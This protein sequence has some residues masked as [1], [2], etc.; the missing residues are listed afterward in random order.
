MNPKIPLRHKISRAL[1]DVGNLRGEKKLCDLPK[2]TKQRSSGSQDFGFWDMCQ[3]EETAY[4]SYMLGNC[5]WPIFN[6]QFNW[7]WETIQYVSGNRTKYQSSFLTCLSKLLLSQNLLQKGFLSAITTSASLKFCTIS[8]SPTISEGCSSNQ[9]WLFIFSQISK[10]NK[11][12]ASSATTAWD[13]CF[14]RETALW[15]SLQSQHVT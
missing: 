10:A 7:Y 3:T 6:T 9:D 14:S 13:N 12:Q 8:P 11:P 1:I 5:T 15:N 4:P 2:F